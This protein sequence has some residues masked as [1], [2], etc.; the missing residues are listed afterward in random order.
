MPA[1]AVAPPAGLDSDSTQ[2]VH[3]GMDLPTARTSL[4]HSEHQ[5]VAEAARCI[6]ENGTLADL[7]SLIRCADST[8]DDRVRRACN[9]AITSLIL[10]NLLTRYNEM[11]SAT[12][13]KLGSIMQALD[14]GIIDGI[15]TELYSDNDER[16][17]RAV[18][19]LGLLRRH[20]K[21]REVLG[22]L[23]Q[24]RDEMIRATAINL[25]GKY[26]G[27]NDHEY[28]LSLLRD[29][30][31][32]VRANTIEALEGLGNRRLIPILIRFR[33]D[34]SNRIRGNVLKALYNLGHQDIVEDLVGMLTS[35][36][37][38]MIASA[39]WVI[40]QTKVTTPELEDRCAKTLISND[41]MVTR[42]ARNAL[43]ALNTPRAQGY[44]RYLDEEPL[45]GA[46]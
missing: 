24:D 13:E 14:P 25:L 27:P 21:V 37:N 32:R 20:P 9:E 28:I 39:L 18:Q 41:E 22:K 15:A 4:T 7:G 3:F 30:D 44:L 17:L 38:F 19:I 8:T 35:K 31:K 23:V 12:R 6:G 26:V 34:P 45:P 5:R 33:K 46:A 36:D 42:N 10:E 2:D 1:P 40:S 11:P 43:R 29:E 16:R